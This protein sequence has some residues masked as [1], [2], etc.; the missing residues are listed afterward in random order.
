VWEGQDLRGHPIGGEASDL[1]ARI[2]QH[3]T[4]HLRGRNLL[5]YVS[6]HDKLLVLGL[7]KPSVG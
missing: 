2:I 6:K 5:N 7:A 3:E 1:E 4:D